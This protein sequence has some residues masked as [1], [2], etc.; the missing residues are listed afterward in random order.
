MVCPSL[1]QP[2]TTG[3]NRSLRA[4]NSQRA[5]EEGSVCHA[6]FLI[7]KAGTG[8]AGV[9]G[10]NLAGRPTRSHAANANHFQHICDMGQLH[11]RPE[12]LR[13][14]RPGGHIKRPDLREQR[15]AYQQV[16]TRSESGIQAS[17]EA[18][19]DSGEQSTNQS[20]LGLVKLPGLSQTSASLPFF[21]RFMCLTRQRHQRCSR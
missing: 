21:S 3:V 16:K 20:R 18:Q 4:I 2:T 8:G 5:W 12:H 14:V 9:Q 13:R 15:C 19:R 6:S 10:N 1:A 11:F 17:R 7:I